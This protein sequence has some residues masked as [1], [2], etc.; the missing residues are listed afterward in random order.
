[1]NRLIRAFLIIFSIFITISCSNKNSMVGFPGS[2]IDIYEITLPD[3]CFQISYTWGDSVNIFER[4]TKLVLGSYDNIESRVLVRFA[5]FPKNPNDIKNASVSLSIYKNNL[6]TDAEYSVHLLTKKWVDN[7]A[8]WTKYSKSSN[9]DSNGGDFASEEIASFTINASRA[10]SIGFS[11]PSSIITQW[12]EQDTTNFGLIIKE[13]TRQRDS[14]FVE[15]YSTESYSTVLS[16][17]LKFDYTNDKG[18]ELVYKNRSNADIFI[19]NAEDN[20]NV[21]DDVLSL[22]NITPR[23]IAMKINIPFELF[24][25]ADSSITSEDDLRLITINRADLILTKTEE[26]FPF[27]NEKNSVSS[28]YL[29][30]PLVDQSYFTKENLLLAHSVVDTLKSNQLFVNITSPIQAYV[31]NIKPNNGLII[32]SNYQNMDFSRINFYNINSVD[33]SKRPKIKIRFSSFRKD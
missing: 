13:K 5:N 28:Y 23:A 21:T 16:P 1:M 7:Q 9:W 20:L 29:T 8:N 24:A 15:F 18:K 19:H 10:D 4:N 31:S 25:E 27:T 30:V 32:K 17:I 2:K 3:S 11:I 12:I 14:Q 26:I 22:W 6:N 33:I